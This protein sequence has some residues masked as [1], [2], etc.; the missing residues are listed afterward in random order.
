MASLSG[1]VLRYGSSERIENASVKATDTKGKILQVITDEDGDFTFADLTPGKWTL[2]ALHETTIPNEPL[3]VELGANKSNV[4]IALQRMAGEVD[5][6]SGK[7]FFN[8]LLIGL[9]SLIVFYVVMHIIFPMNTED[10]TEPFFWDAYP[11]RYVEIVAWA[12]AGILVNKIITCGLY[13]R[14]KCFF[15]EG[16]MMHISHLVATPIMVLVTVLIISLATLTLTIS[17]STDVTL[18]LSQ[19][20]ILIAVSFLLGTSPWPVWEFI[21]KAAK[22]IIGQTESKK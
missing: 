12:L 3:E 15:E 16:I 5:L 17:E 2:L 13:L 7:K 20:P 10:S 18:D 21:E 1:T 8:G 14:S 4:K 22:K 19:L 6:R 9:G 11:W